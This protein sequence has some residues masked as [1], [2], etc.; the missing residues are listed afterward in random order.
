MQF[1][2]ISR[3]AML[4]GSGAA[5]ALPF[6]EA[7][8][9][10]RALASGTKPAARMVAIYTPHGVANEAW[11]PKDY[12]KDYTLSPTLSPLAPVKDAV[13]I[14][15]G[16]CHPR[17]PAG[18]AHAAAARWL[19]GVHEGDRVLNC[20]ASPNQTYSLDQ[21]AAHHIG[22]LTRVPSL[23]LSSQGG[24][25]LPGRSST[26][27]FNSRGIPLPSM[28]KP[29]AVFNRLFV[30]ETEGGKKAQEERYA[31]QQSLLDAVQDEAKTLH[32]ELG[33]SD[34][35][36]LDE[37]L[38]S[39]RDVEVQVERNKKWLHKPKAEV[40]PS[41][42]VFEYEDRSTFIKTM[43]DLILLALRTDTTR[44]ATFMAGVEVD[45]YNWHELGFKHG[46]HG[47]QHHNG[48]E[49][50]LRRLAAVD[51][52]QVEL[53]THFLT[54]LR[55]TNDVD[56]NMLDRTVVLYGSG[57]NNGKG[58]KNGT[59]AHGTRHLPLIFAGGMKL[60]INQGQHLK[61]ESEKTPLCNLHYAMLQAMNIECDGFVDST[62]RLAGV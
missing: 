53:L 22:H 11:Y 41:Q 21:F 1:Q 12:G 26:L 31:R 47:L 17:M 56:G 39:V 23:Q 49:E 52:R 36:R 29:R 9:P 62:G 15:T 50:P 14:M 42:L 25:G 3:R 48:K 44:I 61:F 35:E 45:P 59:G 27:S 2:P 58:L 34:R 38:Q 37:Y 51:K 55:E 33:H 32:K 13:S 4:R 19:A 40:D 16:L 30:P 28:D 7:M 6:L 18:A 57:M 43:Y 5:I 46:Y 24:A 8:M 54:R 10:R 20:F 60:G